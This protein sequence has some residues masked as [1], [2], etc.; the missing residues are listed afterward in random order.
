[1]LSC[2]E[3]RNNISHTWLDYQRLV[4]A[5][6]FQ[7]Q[8]VQCAVAW[9]HAPPPTAHR[10]VV[11]FWLPLRCNS[12]LFLCGSQ[13]Q[14]RSAT[15]SNRGYNLWHRP[16][17]FYES[18]YILYVKAITHNPP[19][20]EVALLLLSTSLLPRND[21]ARN[22]TNNRITVICFLTRAR[23]EKRKWHDKSVHLFPIRLR[24]CSKKIHASEIA[25]AMNN[26][27]QLTSVPWHFS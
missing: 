2:I 12:W 6:C 4:Q 26:F 10:V 13:L 23:T 22:L 24:I 15:L 19:P 16:T 11:R 20:G 9:I 7:E 14:I 5:T 18:W 25:W 27:F 1:M 21:I 17:T 3:D 8:K